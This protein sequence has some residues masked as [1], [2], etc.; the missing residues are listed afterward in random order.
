MSYTKTQQTQMTDQ[1]TLC[2]ALKNLGHKATVQ[3]PGTIRGHYNERSSQKCDVVLRK[4]DTKRQAD[5]GFTKSKDG[6]YTLVTDTYVNRDLE[7]KKMTEFVEGLFV[8]Y[9]KVKVRK[10]AKSV[11]ATFLGERKTATGQI[12]L[13]FAKA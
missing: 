4:E 2:E 8:E 9:N 12:I 10:V 6:S 13:R 3:E 11:G 1:S 7:G 5:I